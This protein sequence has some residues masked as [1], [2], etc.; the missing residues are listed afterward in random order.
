MK[1]MAR[2]EMERAELDSQQI[3]FISDDGQELRIE[4]IELSNGQEGIKITA[5]GLRSDRI[6]IKPVVSNQILVYAEDWIP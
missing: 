6:T 5:S 1:I 3:S 2:H 4:P